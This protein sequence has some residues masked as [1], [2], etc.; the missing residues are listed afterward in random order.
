MV[1]SFSGK[2]VKLNVSSKGFF[3]SLSGILVSVFCLGNDSP[4][5][6]KAVNDTVVNF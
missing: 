4:H 2:V 5:I 1:L 6:D 3:Q